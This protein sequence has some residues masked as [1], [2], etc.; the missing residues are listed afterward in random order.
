MRSEAKSPETTP[1]DPTQDADFDRIY[2]THH[3]Y[4][5]QVCR[6]AGAQCELDDLVQEVF[7]EA[8]RSFHTLR[9][10]A[11]ARAWLRTIA[12]RV[13][14][15]RI[16]G[17]IRHRELRRQLQHDGRRRRTHNPQALSDLQRALLQVPDLEREP[18]ML[19]R[20][21]GCS[22]LETADA[23]GASVAT[24]KRRVNRA[25]QR[26]TRRLVWSSADAA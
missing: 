19:R 5:T 9:E 20:L 7:L 17:R 24:I 14:H 3:R 22:L 1:R 23:C 26:L 16:A 11:A 4:V 21:A 13:V 10:P 18:W 8:Y 12:V 25:H 6:K 2:R 15:R